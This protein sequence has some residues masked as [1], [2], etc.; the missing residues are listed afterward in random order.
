MKTEPR[1]GID[2][3]PDEIMM[4]LIDMAECGQGWISEDNDHPDKIPTS[5]Q[6]AVNQVAEMIGSD[7]R[8]TDE[9]AIAEGCGH[10]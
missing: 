6:E 9:C 8:I 1:G 10:D 3:T 2:M 7:I 4:Q 5:W